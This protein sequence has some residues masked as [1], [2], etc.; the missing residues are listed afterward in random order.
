MPAGRGERAGASLFPCNGIGSTQESRHDKSVDNLANS[1]PRAGWFFPTIHACL[2][3]SGSL[4]GREVRDSADFLPPFPNFGESLGSS[5]KRGERSGEEAALIGAFG[6]DGD[7]AVVRENVIGHFLLNAGKPTSCSYRFRLR[8]GFRRRKQ[9]RRPTA[10][11]ASCKQEKQYRQYQDDFYQP[12]AVHPL[13]GHW[14]SGFSVIRDFQFISTAPPPY[15]S[16]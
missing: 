1:S 16:A 5:G 12:L 3:D 4:E 11:I 8:R 6:P 10:D 2:G 7:A 13:R 15:G 9:E 14:I